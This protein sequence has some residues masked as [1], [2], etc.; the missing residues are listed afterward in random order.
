MFFQTFKNSKYMLAHKKRIHFGFD[1]KKKAKVGRKHA[2]NFEEEYNDY[3]L[4]DEQEPPRTSNRNFY[5]EN[6]PIVHG[7]IC[8]WRRTSLLPML[9]L[10]T[11]EF[12]RCILALCTH[13]IL[14][15]APVF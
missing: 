3:D 2:P 11:A 8:C 5:Q 13:T 10:I 7:S 6:L 15:Y 1:E 4:E 14:V 9:L 12:H